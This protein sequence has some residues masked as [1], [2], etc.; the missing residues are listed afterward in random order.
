[1]N[2]HRVGHLKFSL[3]SWPN[4][5]QVLLPAVLGLGPFTGPSALPWSSRKTQGCRSRDSKHRVPAGGQTWLHVIF[6][7]SCSHPY[8]HLSHPYYRVAFH[9]HRG[10]HFPHPYPHLSHQY[11]RMAF[12]LMG[13]LGGLTAFRE[14]ET[15]ASSHWWAT[16]RMNFT[17]VSSQHKT[18]VGP[19]IS[20]QICQAVR[21]P[22]QRPGAQRR[23]G[24]QV[25]TLHS[26]RRPEATCGHSHSEMWSVRTGVPS[27]TYSHSPY[28]AAL[29]SHW[30][31]LRSEAGPVVRELLCVPL[32]SDFGMNAYWNIDIRT[33][34]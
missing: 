23:E 18:R 27:L 6:G 32:W 21:V 4:P 24:M 8:P 20:S 1:M 22:S 14:W 26:K 12:M 2:L 13:F 11:Y 16:I 3:V 28:S 15:L 10:S 34:Y 30:P 33:E 7:K 19:M 17:I 9:A 29:W 25:G 31:Q 5:A